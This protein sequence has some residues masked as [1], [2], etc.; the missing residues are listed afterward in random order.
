MRAKP[1]P[2][3]SETMDG[4][5]EASS[6]QVEDTCLQGLRIL[7]EHGLLF[8]SNDDDH[9]V[10]SWCKNDKV[11]FND[12]N[13]NDIDKPAFVS[14]I[15]LGGRRL[16]RGLP[17]SPPPFDHFSQLTTLN[18]AGTD[19]PLSDTMT[20]LEQLKALESLY[21]GGNGL[22]VAGGKAL[23]AWL[24]SGGPSSRSLKKLDLRYNDI[25]GAGMMALCQGLSSSSSSSSTNTVQ[26]LYVEGNGIG[27]E[28]AAALAELLVEQGNQ[29]KEQHVKG[30]ENVGLREVFLGANNI[31]ALGARK[32]AAS[33]YTNKQLFKL[34]LEGNN[35]GLEGANAFSAVLEE[36]NG[37]TGLRKLFV[38]NNNIG[39]EGSKRL[40]ETLNSGSAIDDMAL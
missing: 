11:R 30:V 33:L 28:G 21:I 10:N 19:L 40:A 5:A 16:H 29:Q 36:L 1:K 13:N 7:K 4:G 23:G 17:M 18:L 35:I 8:T 32:L 20:V 25:G 3:E 31:Q 9:L 37:D 22:G 38:D 6:R 12:D 14:F 24:R 26:Q 2:A 15:D 27:D 34:Y 39:K